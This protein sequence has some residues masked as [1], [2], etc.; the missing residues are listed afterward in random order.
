[1]FK[2]AHKILVQISSEALTNLPEVT[3]GLVSDN[4]VVYFIM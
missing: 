1:M 4:L 2:E 3:E